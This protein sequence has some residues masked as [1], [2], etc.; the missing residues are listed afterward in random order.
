[1]L[2]DNHVAHPSNL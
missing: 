2:S 1:M